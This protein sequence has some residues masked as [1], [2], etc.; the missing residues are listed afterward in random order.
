MNPD[1]GRFSAEF[2]HLALMGALVDEFSAATK[3]HGGCGDDQQKGQQGGTKKYYACI[4]RYHGIM[5]LV[6]GILTL[7]AYFGLSNLNDR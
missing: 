4:S 7:I 3:R 2:Q 1:T 5:F 6:P